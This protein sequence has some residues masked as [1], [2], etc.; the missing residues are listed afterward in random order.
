MSA[1]QSP[2]AEPEERMQITLLVMALVSL[3]GVAAMWKAVLTF[4]I[5]FGV[6]APAGVGIVVQVPGGGGVGL[7][8]PRCW[9]A[10]AVAMA[11]I[12][13]GVKQQRHRRRVEG[14]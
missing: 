7:D 13:L 8:A 3:V 5:G 9:I 6:L 10:A 2:S 4:L 1:Q 12:G 14:D 11:V